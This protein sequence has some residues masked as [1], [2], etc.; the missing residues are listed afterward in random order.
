MRIVSGEQMEI[1]WIE[2]AGVEERVDES[3]APLARETVAARAP[4][5]PA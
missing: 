2:V 4:L 1:A 5:D 3:D